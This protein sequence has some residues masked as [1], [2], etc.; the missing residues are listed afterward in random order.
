MCCWGIGILGVFMPLGEAFGTLKALKLF[1]FIC[2]ENHIELN[3]DI[4]A[5]QAI[6]L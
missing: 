2:G 1:R 6:E 3:L 5:R 4:V